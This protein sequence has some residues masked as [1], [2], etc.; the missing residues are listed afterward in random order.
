MHGGRRC[1]A[2][3][4]VLLAARPAF[5]GRPLVADDALIL[6]PRECQVEAWSERHSGE[7]QYWV[8]PHCN[9]GGDW[10]LV[11]GAG[12][13]GGAA[14]S[15][16]EGKTVFRTLTV[17]GWAVGM[18]VAGRTLARSAPVW[19]INVPVSVSLYDDAL[20]IH[21]NAGWVR[22]HGARSGAS[23]ALAGEWSVNRSLGL[24]LETYGY[25]ATYAQAGL[26]YALR[27]TGVTLDAALGERLALHG[28]KTRYLAF[29]LTFAP[30]AMR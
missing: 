4:I 2:L 19:S 13:V 10:E 28:D 27:G 6:T 9:P 3:A 30:S 7:A 17:N 21:V 23:W 14:A 15:V 8:A 18:V 12:A 11:A 1:A 16:L 25:G 24:T 29:G 22:Q 20:R 26:R 5:G